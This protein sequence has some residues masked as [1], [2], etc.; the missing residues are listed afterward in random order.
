[1]TG[2]NLVEIRPDV[3]LAQ[4]AWVAACS[5][6]VMVALAPTAYYGIFPRLIVRTD[7]AMTV[8]NI[9]EHQGLFLVGIGC[10]L[11][12]FIGDILVA[13][14]LGIFLRPGSPGLARLVAWFRLGYAILALSAL[15]KLP[16]ILRIVRTPDFASAFGSS[17]LEAQVSAFLWAYRAEWTFGMLIFAVHLLLLG[18][19]VLRCGYVPKVIGILLVVNGLG[20]LVDSLHPYAFPSVKLPYLFLAFFGEIVFMGWLFFRGTRFRTG[21]EAIPNEVSP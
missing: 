11:L 16:P 4:A 10:F 21:D 13:W 5:L 2:R 19:L 17:Q 9:A 20:Y 12:T 3:T 1:M 6:L 8:K 18:I 15:F 7:M 14:S